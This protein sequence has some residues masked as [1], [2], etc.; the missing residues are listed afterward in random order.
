LNWVPS[1]REE[2]ER[3]AQ[4]PRGRPFTPE[5]SRLFELGLDWLVSYYDGLH[6]ARTAY[7]ACEL[8][9]EAAEPVVLAALL[10]DMER[11][12]PGGPV[13]DKRRTPWDDPEYNR[14]HCVRSAAVV[15]DW[16]RRRGALPGFVT[17]VERPILEHEF[18]G[19]PE[20]DLVQAADSL[21]FLEICLP[22]VL[23]WIE[24][25]ECDL[26]KGQA[27]LDFMFHRIRDERAKGLARPYYERR[28]A[29]LV[30]V[31]RSGRATASEPNSR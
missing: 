5:F 2:V 13:L 28:S 3:L 4:L 27:K 10:H 29:E 16:L 23:G 7:W 19:S 14:A 31:A 30:A 24:D 6:L 11:S 20:G 22:R 15:Q 17:G 12:V 1:S 9:P 26:A 25:G 8:D 21:S 18:G